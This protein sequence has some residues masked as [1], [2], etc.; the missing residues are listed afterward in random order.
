MNP[1]S[2]ASELGKVWLLFP[3]RCPVPR[4]QS[5]VPEINYIMG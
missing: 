4:I 1:G 5:Q 2:L 3:I